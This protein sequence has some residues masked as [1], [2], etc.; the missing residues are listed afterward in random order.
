MQG[1]NQEQQQ[2][3]FPA[4]SHKIFPFEI[5]VSSSLAGIRSLR[6]PSQCHGKRCI[7]AHVPRETYSTHTSCEALRKLLWQLQRLR[8]TRSNNK[9]EIPTK[10]TVPG[11]ATPSKPSARNDERNTSGADNPQTSPNPSLTPQKHKYISRTSKA[12]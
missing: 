12:R 10:A 7:W 11:S 9:P 3:A 1:Q 4:A 6:R 5:Q 2:R 8:Q